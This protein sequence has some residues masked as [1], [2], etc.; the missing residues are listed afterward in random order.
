MYI[1]DQLLINGSFQ[2]CLFFLCGSL[3]PSVSLRPKGPE[4][5]AQF[6]K[7]EA[8]VAPLLFSFLRAAGAPKGCTAKNWAMPLLEVYPL[9]LHWGQE[10]MGW[11]GRCCCAR[12]APFAPCGRSPVRSPL[13][14]SKFNFGSWPEPSARVI[15]LLSPARTPPPGGS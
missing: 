10:A 9:L 15:P 6:T 14:A 8:E 7:E 2:N 12:C 13:P 11:I 5:A 4:D 1:S 3:C